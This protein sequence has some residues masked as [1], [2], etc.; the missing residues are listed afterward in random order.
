MGAGGGGVFAQEA[1]AADAADDT[2]AL[3]A[4]AAVFGDELHGD[5]DGNEANEAG[6]DER[7][8]EFM[9]IEGC[10]G[11]GHKAVGAGS[12]ARVF[13]SSAGGGSSSSS[14]S[15]MSMEVCG[16]SNTG[17]MGASCRV[18]AE[19]WGRRFDCSRRVGSALTG[20]S[21]GSGL[22]SCMRMAVSSSLRRL[23]RA[24]P[25]D[26]SSGAGLISTLSSTS[27]TI[28]AAGMKKRGRHPRMGRE[29]RAW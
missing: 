26:L 1:V 8:E 5:D 16:P 23:T 15:S 7:S 22:R 20:R 3:K 9:R 25:S 2:M 19:R 12:G 11:V 27:V 10:Q 4:V 24:T 13:G 29:C 21:R 18:G 14:A 17:C 28:T 6:V